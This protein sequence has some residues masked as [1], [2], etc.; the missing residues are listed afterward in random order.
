MT[1]PCTTYQPAPSIIKMDGILQRV[2]DAN[3]EMRTMQCKRSNITI[4]NIQSAHNSVNNIVQEFCTSCRTFSAQFFSNE[5]ALSCS[6]LKLWRLLIQFS[7]SKLRKWCHNQR[8]E[9][10]IKTIRS[11]LMNCK[12]GNIS[13]KWSMLSSLWY[14]FHVLSSRAKVVDEITMYKLEMKNHDVEIK[15]PPLIR[16]IETAFTMTS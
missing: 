5:K 15:L 6:I 9:N 12:T 1:I 14:G 2:I 11:A 16:Y 3:T 4:I 7:K 13:L 10:Q 8:I